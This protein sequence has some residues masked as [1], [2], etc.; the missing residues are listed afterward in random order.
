MRKI[1]KIEETNNSFA[2]TISQLLEYLKSEYNIVDIS[3]RARVEPDHLKV[4]NPPYDP[5]HKAQYLF[6]TLNFLE[7][8]SWTN[9][10]GYEYCE[11]KL[12]DNLKISVRWDTSCKY[13]SEIQNFSRKTIRKIKLNKLTKN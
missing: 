7:D 1:Y 2:N 11:C 5:W 10:G 3:Y 8:S 13:T 12:T 9:S 6:V 4:G